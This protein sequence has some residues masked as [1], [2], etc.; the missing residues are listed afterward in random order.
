[1]L[2]NVKK[3]RFN[4]GGLKLF[5]IVFFIYIA[6][7]VSY[8]RYIW[9]ICEF[10]YILFSGVVIIRTKQTYLRQTANYYFIRKLRY[11]FPFNL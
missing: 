2:E 6:Y 5:Y 9:L 1:M 11:L 7:L 4:T 10:I 3:A 8:N